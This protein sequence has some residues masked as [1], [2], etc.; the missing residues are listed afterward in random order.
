MDIAKLKAFLAEK[1]REA[2]A[3]EATAIK[4]GKRFALNTAS[5]QRRA[6]DTVLAFVEN[7][8]KEG[9]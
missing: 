8:E 2:S 9:Q 7:S 4:E 6:Y 1:M 3:N 5:E